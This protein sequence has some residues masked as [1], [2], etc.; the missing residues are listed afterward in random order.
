MPLTNIPIPYGIKDIKIFPLT[1]DTPAA[2]GIDFPAAR[3]LSFSESEDS[4]ELRGDDGVVAIHGSGP[5][6][7][8]ELEGGGISFEAV[9]ALYGGRIVESG[10][11][12]NQ[13]KIWNKRESDVRGYNQIEG[14]AISDSGGDVHVALFKCKA[15]GE[16]SGEF[17]DQSYWLTG[18]SGQA[19]G[20]GANRDIYEFQQNETATDLAAPKVP[21]V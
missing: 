17:A 19:I 9:K 8:W 5:S 2:T 4:E 6:V 20:R 16:L 10:V 7:E 18:A 21:T 3:T 1:G 15:T 12:P 11:T 13:T 14:Q